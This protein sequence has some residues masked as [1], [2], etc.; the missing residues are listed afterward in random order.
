MTVSD[1]IDAEQAAQL[2]AWG[3]R[4]KQVP[5]RDIAYRDL[6]HRYRHDEDFA[7]MV[8]AVAAGLR[9]LV[10]EVDQRSGIVLA[11]EPGSVFELKLEDYAS[12]RLP[13]RRDTE[14]VLH[15]LAHLAIAALAFP[16]ADDL[17]HDFYPGRV[18]VELVDT[19]VRETCRVL[20][21]RTER[22]GERH[23]P[24]AEELELERLWRVYVRRPE[25]AET[26]DGRH[27]PET[28]RG[29]V[30]R[31]LG[32]LA[33][34]G[35]LQ[36]VGEQSDEVFRTTGRYQILVRQLAS[37]S[38]LREL[39]ALGVVPSLDARSTSLLLSTEN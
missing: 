29:V 33:D 35:L 5:D 12:T 20:E 8:I 3:L 32:W 22:E 37:Q 27:N 13:K 21:Q 30:R 17:A 28:T 25:V 19:V 15:G 7:A 10:L 9:L 23:D 11:A 34:R 1:R 18:S 39:L 4:G 14:R 2:V 16:R 6:V 26:K 36:P 31:A 24:S 38:A